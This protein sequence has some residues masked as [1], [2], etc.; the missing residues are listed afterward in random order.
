MR[1]SALPMATVNGV[2]AAS[3]NPSRAA[4][5]GLLSVSSKTRNAWSFRVVLRNAK[6][7]QKATKKQTYLS[8]NEI[9]GTPWQFVEGVSDTPKCLIRADSQVQRARASNNSRSVVLAVNAAAR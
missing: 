3:N 9:D 4:R 5:N 2:S 7:S 8:S 6:W 1:A